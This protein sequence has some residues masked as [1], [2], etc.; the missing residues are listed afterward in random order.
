MVRLHDAKVGGSP[1]DDPLAL[2]AHGGLE[3]TR[4]SPGV[5]PAVVNVAQV[6]AHQ[7]EAQSC[8]LNGCELELHFEVHSHQHV[9]H[10]SRQN[11]APSH[12]VGGVRA[13][14]CHGS[15]NLRREGAAPSQGGK[16]LGMHWPD[17]TKLTCVKAAALDANSQ[18]CT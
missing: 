9:G 7:P 18:T 17:S 13:Q 6:H 16:Q 5:E 4:S 11:I 15:V 10:I 1:G 14:A 12:G 3:A 2:P 8:V